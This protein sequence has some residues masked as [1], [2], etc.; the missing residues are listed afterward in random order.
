MRIKENL[1]IDKS[2]DCGGALAS[3]NEEMYYA[4]KMFYFSLLRIRF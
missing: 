2:I 4:K 3:L 1:K